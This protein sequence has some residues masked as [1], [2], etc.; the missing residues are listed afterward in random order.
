V[1][2]LE[3]KMEELRME[4]EHLE[5]EGTPFVPDLS[6]RGDAQK[7]H[8]NAELAKLLREEHSELD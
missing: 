2:A 6:L 4:Q 3:L 7:D 1:N 5:R 8:F